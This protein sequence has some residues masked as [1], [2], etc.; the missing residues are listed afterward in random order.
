MGQ[1]GGTDLSSKFRDSDED[2]RGNKFLLSKILVSQ[3]NMSCFSSDTELKPT[4]MSPQ[5]DGKILFLCHNS[6]EEAADF[7]LFFGK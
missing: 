1:E 2:L 4:E 6:S 5:N 7:F 3:K